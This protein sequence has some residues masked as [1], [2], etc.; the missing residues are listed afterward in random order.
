MRRLR[1]AEAMDDGKEKKRGAEK[2]HRADE[3]VRALGFVLQRGEVQRGD[4]V[5]D[6]QAEAREIED[7]AEQD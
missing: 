5:E 4:V 1:V 2:E 6:E 3:I 7:I